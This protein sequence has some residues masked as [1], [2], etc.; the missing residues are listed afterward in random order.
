MSDT[1]Y[2]IGVDFGTLSGRA[3][4]VDLANGKE[5]AT[6]VHEYSNGVIDECLPSGAVRLMSAQRRRPPGTRLGAAR[7]P[8]LH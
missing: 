7:S 5:L 6:A 2:A 3:V 1:K 4:I 8:R